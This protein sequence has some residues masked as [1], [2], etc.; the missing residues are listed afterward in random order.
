MQLP[1]LGLIIALFINTEI[2][3]SVIIGIEIYSII[4]CVLTLLIAFLNII[5]ALLNHGKNIPSPYKITMAIKLALIPFYVIN[6][7]IWSI[8]V[9]GSL[10]PFFFIFL[11]L[12][13]AFSI[14][15]TYFIMLATSLQNIVYLWRQFVSQKKL[16]Y[17]IYAILHFIFCVDVIGSILVYCDNKTASNYNATDI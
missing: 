9:I 10:N 4:M 17:L 15:T 14:I 13:L 3:D 2:A 7:L 1:F 6:F 16:S 11:P 5:L 12:F 8:F